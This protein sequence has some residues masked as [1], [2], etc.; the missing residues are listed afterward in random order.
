[1]TPVEA[2]SRVIV[3]TLL[4]SHATTRAARDLI[5]REGTVVRL[6]PRGTSTY[7]LVRMDDE[8]KGF[9]GQEKWPIQLADL[10]VISPNQASR[11][12]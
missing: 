5:G 1:M 7:A 2:G 4:H 8:I 3:A 6:I 9:P 12:A 10:V 11:H